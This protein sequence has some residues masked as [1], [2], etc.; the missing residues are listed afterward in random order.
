MDSSE[1]FV[2]RKNN[3]LMNKK[4]NKGFDKKALNLMQS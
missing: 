3:V 2:S 4:I 1:A